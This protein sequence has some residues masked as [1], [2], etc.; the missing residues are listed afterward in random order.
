MKSYIDDDDDDDDDEL[1]RC[2]PASLFCH[3]VP[4]SLTALSSSA[5]IHG[6]VVSC[7]FIGGYQFDSNN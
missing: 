2:V 5:K 4:R 1:G 7:V 6:E 3:K